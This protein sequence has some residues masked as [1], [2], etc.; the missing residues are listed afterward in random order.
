MGSTSVAVCGVLPAAAIYRAGVVACCIHTGTIEAPVRDGGE[1][2]I[3]IGVKAFTDIAER[4]LKTKNKKKKSKKRDDYRIGR[5]VYHTLLERFFFFFL[6][7]SSRMFHESR[8]CRYRTMR[9][10]D[11]T[12]GEDVFQPRPFVAPVPFQLLWR[13]R[14][15]DHGRGV[16]LPSYVVYHIAHTEHFY[17]ERT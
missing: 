1:K 16:I 11:K 7:P 10:S 14:S 4:I 12:L 3:E 15:P 17:F 13:Y 5:C 9:S 6:L 2:N 8:G